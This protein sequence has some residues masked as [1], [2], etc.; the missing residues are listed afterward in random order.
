MKLTFPLLA[1]FTVILAGACG[2]KATATPTQDAGAIQTQAMQV[3]ATQF[4]MQQTQTAVANESTVQPTATVPPLLVS[5]T[6]IVSGTPGSVAFTPFSTTPLSTTPFATIIPTLPAS[7]S[8]TTAN[9][10]NDSQFVSETIP[11]KTTMS[12]GKEFTKVWEMLNTGTCSWETGYVFAFLPDVSTAGF[13]GHDVVYKA[14]D[15]TTSPQHSQSFVLKLK[16]PDKAGEYFGYWKMKDASGNFFGAR[17]Y[18]D[19]IVQ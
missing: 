2:P 4:F 5:P 1:I 14:S 12:P 8:G 6:F 3:V 9:G 11:D 10:C 19:I 16:A 7:G 15:A 17:V 18:V 13:I